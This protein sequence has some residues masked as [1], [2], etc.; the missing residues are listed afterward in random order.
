[1]VCINLG[2]YKLKYIYV[3]ALTISPCSAMATVSHLPHIPGFNGNMD[4]VYVHV[5]AYNLI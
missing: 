1:M 4:E 3:S 5:S 2:F